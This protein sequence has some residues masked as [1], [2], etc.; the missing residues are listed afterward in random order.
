M[1]GATSADISNGNAASKDELF[2]RFGP[3]A[4]QAKAAYDPNGDK[5]LPVAQFEVG[6]DALMSEPA[7][8]TARTLAAQGVTTYEYRF[9]YTAAGKR[10]FSPFGAPHASELPFVFAKVGQRYGEAASPDDHAAARLMHAYW[11]NFARTGNPN[12]QGLPDWP[13]YTPDSDIILTFT[14]DASAVAGPDPWKQRLNVT[15]A[16][17]DGG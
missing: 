16:K 5:P 9:A 13:V 4:A 10:A 15:A 7:R 2:A 17:A 11:V 12:G 1:V 8:M 6:M 3:L 14:P